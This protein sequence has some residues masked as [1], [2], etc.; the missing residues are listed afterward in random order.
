[1]K[2]LDKRAGIVTRRF[3]DL[4][5]C[6]G[7]RFCSASLGVLGVSDGIDG[8]QWSAWYSHEDETS[9]LGVN[10]E[11]R[12]YEA[13]PT[14]RLIEREISHPR[15][16]TEYRVTVARPDRVTVRWMRDAWQAS[17]RVRIRKCPYSGCARSA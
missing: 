7:Q 8:V 2:V 17:G 12:K 5:G 13:W 6:D 10:L 14:V 11:G 3:R 9:W 1:M 4:F 16:L 15:L